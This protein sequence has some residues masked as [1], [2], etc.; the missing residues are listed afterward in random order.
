MF[1]RGVLGYLPVNIV[2]GVVGLLTIVLFT[3]VLSPEQYGVYA[4]A[5]SVYTLVQTC[6]LTWTEAAMAR[7]LATRAED[8]RLADHFATLYRLWFCAA[9]LV[10]VGGAV[11]LA[12]APLHAT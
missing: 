8:G 7:F 5:F 12:F 9:L 4:L 1:W 11:V 10:P 3:R 6:L 2:Q